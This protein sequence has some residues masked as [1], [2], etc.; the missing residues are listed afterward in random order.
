MLHILGSVIGWLFAKPAGTAQNGYQLTGG[1][2]NHTADITFPGTP[3]RISI[4]QRYTGLD[5]FDQLRLEGEVTGKFKLNSVTS[6]K[7]IFRIN[8]KKINYNF[9]DHI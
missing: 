9:N 8:L 3:H 2:F 1:V 6:S 4:T 5:L 7:I